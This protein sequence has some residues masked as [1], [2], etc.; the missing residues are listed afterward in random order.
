MAYPTD[1]FAPRDAGVIAAG[2]PLDW[3]VL[4]TAQQ[5]GQRRLRYALRRLV[6]LRTA[7][8]RNVLI[9]RVP[10]PDALLSDLAALRTERP[11]LDEWLGKVVPIERT[12]LVDVARFQEQLQ[13][14]VGH[15]LDRLAGRTFHVRVERRGHK[16]TINT[17][18]CEQALGDYVCAALERSGIAP[19]V[20]F[21]NPA[22]VLA[23]EVLG[24]VA[25]IG[26]V[27]RE[28]RQ[29]F[30]FVKMD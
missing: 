21:A 9:G 6:R 8:F 29:R 17:H 28:Q 2:A 1:P 19:S 30:P 23:V 4:V 18:R 3:N 14:Q 13:E 22:A 20:A 12:F 10:A 11:I 26:F 24:P 7:G 16:G 5:G 27:T 25:G 15:F